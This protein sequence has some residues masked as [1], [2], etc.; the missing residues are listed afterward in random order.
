MLDKLG[1]KD[2][3]IYPNNA[4]PSIGETSY[5]FYKLLSRFEFIRKFNNYHY[6]LSATRL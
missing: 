1:F 2:I 3:K 5:Q 6:M 4:Y